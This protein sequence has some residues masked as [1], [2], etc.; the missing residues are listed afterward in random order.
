MDAIIC[1]GAVRS[2]KTLVMGVSFVC[3]AMSRFT[4]E[5]FGICGKTIVSL[6]RNVIEVIVPL[7]KELGFTCEDSMSRNVLTVKNRAG[8]NKFYLFGGKDEGS[9]ALVQGITLAGIMFDEAALQPR[10]FVEQACARCSVSG[11]KFWFNCNPEG[12]EHW[13]YKEWILKAK[14]R[15]AVYLHFTMED[16]PSLSK[17]IRKRYERLYSGAF[18]QRFVLGKWV[19]AEGRVYD[20]FDDGYIK[21]VP[22]TKFEKWYIS[23]DYGTANPASFGLWGFADGTWYRVKEYYFASREAGYQKTDEEYADELAKLAGERRISGVIV[24]PSAASFIE[25]LKRRGYAPIRAKNDVVAGIRVTADLLKKEK[26]VICEPCTDAIREFSV[27]VWD[28]HGSGDKPKKENDHAMDDIRYFAATV[29][30]DRDDG[31]A[32]TF[33]ER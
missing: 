9:A 31:F 4:G 2:G 28:E 22:D 27:Y 30:V 18:Y 7:L 23:C 16:N 21:P 25:V 24:D 6:R 29:A 14:E 1:D 12:P 17:E 8:E 5:R 13:F 33:V 3:W 15:R 11:S 32:A 10:S 20:F 19:S 26:I